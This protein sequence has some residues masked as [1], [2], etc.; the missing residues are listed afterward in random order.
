MCAS[1]RTPC[2]WKVCIAVLL[3]FVVVQVMCART[4]FDWKMCT[5]MSDVTCE[6]W[7]YCVCMRWHFATEKYAYCCVVR[8]SFLC[9]LSCVCE[10]T[11]QLKSVHCYVTCFVMDIWKINIVTLQVLCVRTPWDWKVCIV[12]LLV[13]LLCKVCVRG[14]P[15]T[16]KYH[17]LCYL[18][19][20][21]SATYVCEDILRLKSLHCWGVTCFV[22][23]RGHP[24]CY[25]KVHALLVT[26]FAIEQVMCAWTPCRWK[27]WI[28]VLL[29]F[30]FCKLCVRGHPANAK[31]A[32]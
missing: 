11:L 26:C 31:Y 24:A 27:V 23:V 29:V 14:H 2:D 7:C 16:G 19:C 1:A 4:P 6:L 12:M 25:W 10:A 32:F 13:L 8:L 9:K 30:L 17:L 28:A 5:A 3:C 22:I 20:Y 15:A 18:C 21:T